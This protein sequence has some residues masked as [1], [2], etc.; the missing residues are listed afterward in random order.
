MAYDTPFELKPGNFQLFKNTKKADVKHADWTGSIKLPDGRE[1]WFNMYNKEGAKGSYF[2]GYI[3]K[4]KQQLDQPGSFNSFA[5]SAPLGRPEN[6]H[7]AAPL[8]D[9]PF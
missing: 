1:Y 9:V 2:S 7:P 5:P 4:E 6:F 8:D 3:G